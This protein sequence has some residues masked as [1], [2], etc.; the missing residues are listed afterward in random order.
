MFERVLR[1]RPDEPQSYR[2]LALVL[3]KRGFARLDASASRKKK[4]PRAPAAAAG[5][6]ASSS[7]AKPAKG[8]AAKAKAAAQRPLSELRCDVLRPDGT[9]YHQG[10][11]FQCATCAFTEGEVI[12]QN[13]ADVRFASRS[14][15]Q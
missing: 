7:S 14:T 10:V 12:C 3:A 6:S 4:K 15:V 8:K 1:L 13:C 9:E 11:W 5:A 2:D